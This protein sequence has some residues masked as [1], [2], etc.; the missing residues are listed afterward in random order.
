ME[1]T[2]DEIE[3]AERHI[4]KRE[5]EL[6]RWP[7]RRWRLLV[8]Y[9]VMMLVGCL[10]VNDGRR[11]IDE[12]QSTEAEVS[13]ALGRGPIPG[14]EDRWVV[15]AMIKVGVL[16]E[17]RHQVVTLSLMQMAAGLMP[18]LGGVS[19]IGIILVRWNDGARDALICKLLRMKLRELEQGAAAKS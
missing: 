9:S 3:L 14:M 18:L 5:R 17:A 7:R 11:S 8:I 4:A 1:L 10:I 13:R 6:A 15:G 12:D 16:L 2:K 19:M